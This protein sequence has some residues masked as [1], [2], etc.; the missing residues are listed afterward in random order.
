MINNEQYKEN[1]E[2][3][4]NELDKLRRPHAVPKSRMGA[5]LDELPDCIIN[6]IIC[7]SESPEGYVSIDLAQK[8]GDLIE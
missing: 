2:Y 3:L 8:E 5:I 7:I 4:E 6:R 1:M